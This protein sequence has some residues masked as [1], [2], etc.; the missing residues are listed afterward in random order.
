MIDG[1][2]YD[3]NGNLIN[4]EEWVTLFRWK[5]YLRMLD[6]HANGFVLTKWTGIDMPPYEMRT[7]PGFAY[8]SWVPNDPPL[9][10][11]S[12]VFDLDGKVLEER[13]YSDAAKA[14]AGHRELVEAYS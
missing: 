4:A 14:E 2:F 10:N 9:V 1:V 7:K 3:K 13:Q 8:K 5:D 12:L 11:T 6:Q